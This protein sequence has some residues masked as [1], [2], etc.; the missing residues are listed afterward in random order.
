MLTTL[1]EA[2]E[3][4]AET[5]ARHPERDGLAAERAA[6]AGEARPWPCLYLN[7]LA[8]PDDDTDAPAEFTPPACDFP[9]G[10]AGDL[11]REIVDLLAPLDM[12]NPVRAVLSPGGARSPADLIPSFGTPLSADGGA[13]AYARPIADLLAAPPPDPDTSGHMGDLREHVALVKRLTP[14]TFSISMPDLQGPFNLMHALAGD[15]AFL[16]PQTRPDAY[17][18]LMTRVTDFWIAACDRLREW[19]GPDRLR[20]LDRWVCITECSVNLVSPEFY[21]RHILPYDLRIAR[22]FGGVRI[23]P[24]SGRHVFHATLD[25]LPG[26][27]AT[28][29]GMM[30]AQMAAPCIGVDEALRAI[31]ERPILLAVGQELPADAEEAFELIRADLARTRHNPRLLF[32]YTG[33]YW[34]RRDRPMIRD[35]HRRLDDCWGAP[36]APPVRP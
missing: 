21:R 36:A 23:H 11:A 8:A 10:P 20:P 19:I 22:H 3:L 25:A 4:F 13:A 28:E 29:A 30:L 2:I 27:A 12:L 34:R 35:L 5:L 14:P 24:C 1:Q 7:H 33:M 6:V 31:G 18:R 26:V 32:A 9:P 15:E 17:R 16:A